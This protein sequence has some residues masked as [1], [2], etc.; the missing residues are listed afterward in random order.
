[1]KNKI[2]FEYNIECNYQT[3]F[4]I[5]FSHTKKRTIK[6]TQFYCLQERN[7]IKYHYILKILIIKM[8]TSKRLV[9]HV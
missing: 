4:F 5:I 8:K 7:K 3:A 1:M 2:E 6:P 9:I